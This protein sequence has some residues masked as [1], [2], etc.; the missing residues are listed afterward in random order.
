MAGDPVARGRWPGRRERWRRGAGSRG[1]G[2]HGGA[3]LGLEPDLEPVVGVAAEAD[4]PLM[5]D[6]GWVPPDRRVFR[7]L[8]PPAVVLY[9]CRACGRTFDAG[10]RSL[11]TCLGVPR[12][13]PLFACFLR[14][15]IV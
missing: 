8:P 1:A 4:M 12:L 9:V 11:F 5:G 6:D 15:M 7:P 3:L 2:P 13:A 14:M 10:F